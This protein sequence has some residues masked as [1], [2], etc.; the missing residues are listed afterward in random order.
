MDDGS[1]PTVLQKFEPKLGADWIFQNSP[2]ILLIVGPS[3]N[4]QLLFN[5]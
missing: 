5:S 2:T 4:I 3:L 1:F